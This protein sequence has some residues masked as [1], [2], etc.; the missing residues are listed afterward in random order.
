MTKYLGRQNFHGAVL[1]ISADIVGLDAGS[2]EDLEEVYRHLE[3][4]LANALDAQADGVCTGI[5][6]TVLTG[7]IVLE[8]EHVVAVVQLIH[9]LGLACVNLFHS[10]SPVLDNLFYLDKL[11]V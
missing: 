2:L 9:I 7:Y 3:V 8:F 6:Y 1:Q 11:P 10:Y 4:G 5:E